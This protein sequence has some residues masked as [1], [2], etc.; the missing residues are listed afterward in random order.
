[1]FLLEIVQLMA[2]DKPLPPNLARTLKNLYKLSER[3]A[4]KN[5]SLAKGD[6]KEMLSRSCRWW[7]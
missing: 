4:R 6:H 3:W 5:T 1:M 2:L 7:K